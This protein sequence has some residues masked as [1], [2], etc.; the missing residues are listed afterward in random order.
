MNA[1]QFP[2]LVIQETSA[3]V[4]FHQIASKYREVQNSAAQFA[5]RWWHNNYISIAIKFH[6]Q[7]GIGLTK[8]KKLMPVH[9]QY[10]PEMKRKSI[11][12]CL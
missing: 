1:N 12:V 5:P 8:F 9:A 3:S 4:T 6:S 7:I 10:R 2:S 11:L